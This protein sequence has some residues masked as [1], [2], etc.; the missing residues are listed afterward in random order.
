MWPVIH[1]RECKNHQG[2]AGARP[3]PADSVH[4]TGTYSSCWAR[5]PAAA[6]HAGSEGEGGPKQAQGQKQCATW[7]AAPARGGAIRWQA[8]P[9]R[10]AEHSY[11]PPPPRVQCHHLSAPPREPP[12]RPLKGRIGPLL[13]AATPL[14]P[15][16]GARPASARGPA[17]PQRRRKA[18]RP[19]RRLVG[20]PWRRAAGSSPLAG[21]GTIV[22]PSWRCALR[23]PLGECDWSR[24]KPC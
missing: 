11:A 15:P 14:H 3:C 20:P 5:A 9:P 18:R 7:Q 21:S 4:D 19:A 17:A 2:A 8:P 22:G 1:S 6:A 10:V 23:G 13:P 16:Q 24:E 12:C